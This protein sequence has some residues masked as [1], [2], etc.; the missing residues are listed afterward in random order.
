MQPC[1]RVQPCCALLFRWLMNRTDG[2]RLRDADRL[3][4]EE[5]LDAELA[6]LLAHA[7]DADSSE[8]PLHPEVGGSVDQD[9]SGH[10]LLGDAEPAGKVG[11]LDVT[12]EAIPGV[13]G[14]LYGI[15]VAVE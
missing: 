15:F 13:V 6:A 1:P 7:R 12:R 5:L 2:T 9:L 10:Q 11:G 8:W 3:D 14:D 4:P